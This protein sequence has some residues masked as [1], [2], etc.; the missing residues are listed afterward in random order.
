MC[1][2]PHFAAARTGD[3][4]RP[5][6]GAVQ[7]IYASLIICV[8]GEKV[9]TKSHEKGGCRRSIFNAPE[10]PKIPRKKAHTGGKNPPVCVCKCRKADFVP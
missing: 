5:E 7:R 1:L 8:D 4:A 10:F 9:N 2:P 3:P 6:Y